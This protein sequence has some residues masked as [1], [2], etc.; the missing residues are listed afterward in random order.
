MTLKDEPLLI[1]LFCD[2]RSLENAVNAL[3][4]VGVD[5]SQLSMLS[6]KSLEEEADDLSK[7]ASSEQNATLARS[8]DKQSVHTETD[9][10]Q[11]RTLVSGIAGTAGG[12]VGIGVAMVAG[13][14]ALP[15][16]AVAAGAGLGTAAVAHAAGRKA[17]EEELDAL[18][19]QLQH[20]GIVLWVSPQ[21]DD[22]REKAEAILRQNAARAFHP[23]EPKS[24]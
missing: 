23:E 14:A 20:G 16:L 21:N 22:E 5:R 7:D 6:W 15:A 17:S 12:S 3:Q 11:L 8:L 19:V 24:S 13:A 9:V 10:R 18:R 4:S 2:E 1:G